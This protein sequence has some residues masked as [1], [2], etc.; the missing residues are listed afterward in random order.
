[1]SLGGR[2]GCCRGG[3]PRVRLLRAVRPGGQSCVPRSGLLLETRL[4]PE[5]LKRV[6]YSVTPGHSELTGG[7]DARAAPRVHGPPLPRLLAV[8]GFP[9]P[10]PPAIPTTTRGRRT[11][12]LCRPPCSR[13]RARSACPR[14]ATSTRPLSSSGQELGSRPGNSGAC[15][16]AVIA[17]ATKTV[18]DPARL[19]TG[20]GSARSRRSSAPILCAS[21]IASSRS[22][23]RRLVLGV[24]LVLLPSAWMPALASRRVRR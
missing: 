4:A 7:R 23:S 20:L 15:E 18:T 19:I 10:S 14:P 11:H 12:P 21:D 3:E 17:E 1:M 2:G 9:A 8:C 16:D 5:L 22:N 24:R 13:P 6:L